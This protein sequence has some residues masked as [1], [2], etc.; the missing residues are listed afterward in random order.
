MIWGGRGADVPKGT[1]THGS[2]GNANFAQNNKI[3]RTK[4]FTLEGQQIYSDAAGV[5]IK[6]VGDLTDA[7]KSG[8]LKL[9]QVPVDFV[10]MN[11]TRLIL[12]TRTSTALTN[13]GIPK[14]QWFGRNR[15]G[16]EAF[17]G[18]T[19]DQLAADQLKRN[20]LPSTGATELP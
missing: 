4:E 13:A 10:D 9:S 1:A 2:V 3:P 14:S 16:V 20:G 18:K 15:T 5:P 11:G 7:L 19:F 12:N 8:T 17:P 6:T